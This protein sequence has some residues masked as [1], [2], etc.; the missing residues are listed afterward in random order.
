MLIEDRLFQEEFLPLFR[1]LIRNSCVNTGHPDSGHEDRSVETLKEFFGRRG[2]VPDVYHAR[3]GRGN[4]VVRVPGT[5]PLAPSLMFMGHLDVVPAQAADWSVDPFAAE[6]REGQIWG[7]GAVDMLCWTAAQA[8]GF[9]EA[10]ARAPGGR[11]QGDLIFLALA[12]E[13]AS[14]RWGAQYLTE[15]HWEAV[16]TD[17]MVT[18]LGGFFI[19]TDRGAAA[20]CTVGEKGV[21]WVRLACRGT[22]GHGSMPY[23]ADNAAVKAARAVAR[24]SRMRF[25]LK[26]SAPYRAMASAM[27]RGWAERLALS[28]GLGE[29]WALK[30]LLRRN[31]GMARFLHTAGRPTFSPNVIRSG[32]KVNIVADRAEVLV[33]CR[34]LPATS[35]QDLERWIRKALGRRLSA[36]FSFEITDWFPSNLS[37]SATPLRQAIDTLF[38]KAHPGARLVDLF[39]GGVTDG[40][41]WRARGTTVYGYTLFSRSLTMD[42]YGQRIHG[43]DER[44]DLESLALGVGFFR[45]LP[46]AFF[47]RYI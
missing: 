47:S 39:I 11:F 32:E 22:P 38:Q 37:E 33:D 27:A 44:I 8:V 17:F 31:P 4:L 29:G 41:F 16:K 15:H 28:T 25:P 5:N 35:K 43:V 46:D 23:G 2:L 40:R 7:R 3:E 42:A 24:L 10:V 26:A 20:F 14:G 6:L 30:R 45:D 9:A 13:E 18:E 1:Q 19:D 12:D 34:L 36:E 21:A